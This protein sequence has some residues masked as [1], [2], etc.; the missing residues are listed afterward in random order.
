MKLSELRDFIGKSGGEPYLYSRLVGRKFSIYFSY[1]LIKLKVTPNQVTFISLVSALLGCLSLVFSF[2]SPYFLLLAILFINLYHILDHSDG[3][4]ARYYIANKLKKP[5]KDGEY[6]DYIVHYYSTNLMFFCLG[7][8]LYFELNQNILL[9][10]FGL[11]GFIGMS[12]FHNLAL[13]HVLLANI[14]RNQDIMKNSEFNKILNSASSYDE[15][16]N[17]LNSESVIKKIIK[18]IKETLTFPG[19]M[20]VISIV[21]LL[22]FIGSSVIFRE[23]YLFFIGIFFLLNCIRGPISIIRKLKKIY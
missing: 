20:A 16:Q 7:L 10:I 2:I 22:D 4:V 21:A 8:G 12:N 19:C 17:A 11:M 18:L 14:N 6:F 5:S 1:L 15:L 23:V 3:E 9:I 13:S